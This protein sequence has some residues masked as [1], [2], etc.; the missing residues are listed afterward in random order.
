PNVLEF[1]PEG[2][3][4]GHWGGP[5][6]GYTWPA[7]NHGISIDPEGNFWIA[8]SGPTDTRLL[9]FSRDGRF[10]M[11]VGKAV[12]VPP[13]AAV[14]AA[15]TA[16][17]G[18]APRGGGR[19]GRGGRGGPPPPTV[20]PNSTSLESFGGAAEITFDAST[21]EGFVADGYRNRRVAVIDY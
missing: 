17:Q 15:D 11:E 2:N 6:Q 14:A 4:V 1:D 18:V 13:R 20:P 19:G 7:Q 21:G 3:L 5:G 16:Y 9:K 8:G 10:L 12:P